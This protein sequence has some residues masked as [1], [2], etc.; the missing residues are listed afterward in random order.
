MS[1]L[2]LYFFFCSAG[3]SRKMEEKNKS[4]V[5]CGDHEQDGKEREKTE[6]QLS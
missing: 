4:C 3:F 6:Q 2:F 5:A 1:Q